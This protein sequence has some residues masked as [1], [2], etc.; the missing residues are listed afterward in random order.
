MYSMNVLVMCNIN[1]DGIIYVYHK[2][3]LGDIK[4]LSNLFHNVK[5]YC[6]C[7]RGVKFW[8]N[9]VHDT[10]CILHMNTYILHIYVS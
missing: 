5:K 3:L 8:F 6:P 9:Y 7:I 2:L 10:D 4:I 1:W